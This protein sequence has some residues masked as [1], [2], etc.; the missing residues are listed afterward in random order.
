M[1]SG[2]IPEPVKGGG[3]RHSWGVEITRAV[4]RSRV[5]GAPG[6]L[7]NDSELGFGYTPIPQSKRAHSVRGIDRS[8]FRL[9]ADANGG[10][11]FLDCYYM[12][13]A[14]LFK[15]D[16]VVVTANG[17]QTAAQTFGEQYASKYAALDIP[18]GEAA[19]IIAVEPETMANIQQDLKRYIRPLYLFDKS[20][21]V[22][23]DL[24]SMP[25]IQKFEMFP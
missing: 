2:G 1:L 11:G 25:Q 10:Y 6:M 4:N 16:D 21:A 7:C 17:S 14:V 19:S 24:R 5:V 3:V 9:G 8:P 23:V 20:G 15:I 13:G 12:I 22:A 18:K